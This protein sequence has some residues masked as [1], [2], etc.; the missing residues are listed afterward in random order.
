MPT[1]SIE[2]DGR[3]WRVY[4]SGFVTQYGHDEFALIFMAGTDP[5]REVRVARYSPQGVRSREAS[6]GEMSDERLTELFRT[7]QPSETS[8]EAGYSR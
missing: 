8:P 3:A 4:P 5:Q 7:S 1:R 2:I 6:L